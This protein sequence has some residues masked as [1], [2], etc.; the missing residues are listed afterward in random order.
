M[1][2][3]SN[4]TSWASR[5]SA[6]GNGTRRVVYGSTELYSANKFIEEELNPLGKEMT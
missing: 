4:L 2:E 1:V 3:H 6:A 5:T